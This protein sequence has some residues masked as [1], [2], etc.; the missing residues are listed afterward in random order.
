[1]LPSQND[2]CHPVIADIKNDQFAI[3]TFDKLERI[4]AE[5]LVLFSL[6]A[7]KPVQSQQK[8]ITKIT[9][10]FLQQ[11]VSLNDNHI[12]FNDIPLKK[13]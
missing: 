2:D 5:P 6:D 11:P 10:R 8:L 7:F 3:R 13:R 12:V 4:L 9:K 1:M